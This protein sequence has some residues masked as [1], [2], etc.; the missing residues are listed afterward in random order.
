MQ[1]TKVDFNEMVDEI[2]SEQ[3]NTESGKGCSYGEGPFKKKKQHFHKKPVQ[4]R[5]KCNRFNGFRR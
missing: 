5:R 4:I 3:T 1:E 2:R